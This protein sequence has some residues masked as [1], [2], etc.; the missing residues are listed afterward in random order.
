MIRGVTWLLIRK[1]RFLL[2]M[3][4]VTGNHLDGASKFLPAKIRS[5]TCK[6][7]FIG[8]SLTGYNNLPGMV[9]ELAITANKKIVMDSF[10]KYGKALYEIS[11]LPQ[12]QEKICAQPWDYIV[13]QDG[14]HNAAYPDSYQQL[15]PYAAYS[16]LP[17]TLQMMRDL[18]HAHCESTKVVY[19]MPWAFKDGITWIA[20]QTDTYQAM[21]KKILQNS[22]HFAKALDLMIAPVGW[23]WYRVI[24]ERPNI[25]LFHP[26]WSHA[27]LRGSYLAA[28]VF[29]AVFF[30]EKVASGYKS[31]LS[32]AEADYFQTIASATVLD[33]LRRWRIG[34]TAVRYEIPQTPMNFKLFQ[35]YPNPFN[36]VTT[37]QV[38]LNRPATLVINIYDLQ[39]K[40]V[41]TLSNSQNS[42]PGSYQL[43]WDGR[44]QVGM[45]APSGAYFYR[46]QTAT[47]SETKRLLLVR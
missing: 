4:L 21:Q 38:S 43:N 35:N 9:S 10:L 18:I 23:A 28:C 14:C 46:L 47:F 12:I 41:R 8:N 39:G 33:S 15:I 40:L 22:I 44:D 6:I 42:S 26:D 27:A 37:I 25:E 32:Q 20:G 17:L 31:S 19:F 3:L 5:D 36:Q 11:Q 16:P 45:A 2:L 7:L 29:Y 1:V 34:T 30:Q 24:G 13:L